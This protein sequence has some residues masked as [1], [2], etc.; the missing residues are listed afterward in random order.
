MKPLGPNRIAAIEERR[1]PAHC[2]ICD[3]LKPYRE[4]PGRPIY[5]CGQKA[6]RYEWMKLILLDTRKVEPKTFVRGHFRKNQTG[7]KTVWVPAH[8]NYR[9]YAAEGAV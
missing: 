7:T 1:S 9:A 5:T 8:R 2:C 4:N 3:G 6:C